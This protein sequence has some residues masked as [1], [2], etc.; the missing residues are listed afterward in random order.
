[1]LPKLGELRR[2]IVFYLLGV[3]GTFHAAPHL[4]SFRRAELF[5]LL[6]LFLVLEF[7][8]ELEVAD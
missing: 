4:L 1:M 7:L 5:G 6:Y 2:E 3:D 8:E